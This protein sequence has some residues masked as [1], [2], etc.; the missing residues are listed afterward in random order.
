V[1]GADLLGAVAWRRVNPRL[2]RRAASL[3]D[4]ARCEATDL[5]HGWRSRA[6]QIVSPA[7]R[8]AGPG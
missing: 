1:S 2:R 3:R 4:A 5:R 6:H 7:L 8:P